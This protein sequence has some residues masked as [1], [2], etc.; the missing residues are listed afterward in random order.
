M[1]TDLQDYSHKRFNVLTGEWVLVSPHRAKRPWQGQNEA[2]N[3]EVRPSHDKSCYLCAGNTRINGEINPD[4]KDVFVFTNDFAALQTS[5]KSFNV[6]DGLLI[7]QSEQGICKVIC[8]SPDH[9]KSLA[10]MAPK[11]IEKVVLTWQKEYKELGENPLINY[12]QIFENKGAVMGCSNPHPH[13]QIW[14]QSTLPN[15]VYKKDLQQRNYFETNKASLLKNYISQELI[16]KERII[17]E[18]E[19]FVV[20]V[21]FWAIWPFETMIVPKKHQTSILDIENTES[22]L[23]AEAIAVITKA[24][25]KLFNT[26]FPYSSGIH[27][28]PT[29]GEANSHWHWHM[30]FYPPLLRSATVKKFMVGYEM[31]GSPQRDITPEIAAKMVR[32][33]VG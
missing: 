17:F 33:L 6:N 23:F 32:D 4:Y 7:A 28:A 24:Y 31:F 10:D 13:G 21:P 2:V 27:Q 20:L 5:S 12:V 18:N 16:Q 26:S 22:L 3:N 14:S 30:S 8:F 25:D 11:D 29:N 19:A 9:S 1:N 15:E